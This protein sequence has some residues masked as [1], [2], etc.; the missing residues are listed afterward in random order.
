MRLLIIVALATP[1]GALLSSPAAGLGTLPPVV[2]ASLLGFAAG[3][4]IYVAAADMMPR[5]HRHGDTG[6][7]LYFAAGLFG[8]AALRL[9]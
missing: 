4:F 5:L 6:G 2:E 9:F 3:S 1:L 7:V 8:M